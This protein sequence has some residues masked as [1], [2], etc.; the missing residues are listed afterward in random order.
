MQSKKPRHGQGLIMILNDINNYGK[1][2][3]EV[4]EVII[5]IMKHKQSWLCQSKICLHSHKKTVAMHTGLSYT[6]YPKDKCHGHTV[7]ADVSA[8]WSGDRRRVCFL[9]VQQHNTVLFMWHSADGLKW[10]E[11]SGNSWC[12]SWSFRRTFAWSILEWRF[13]IWA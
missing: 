13:L 9:I 11:S 7:I 6:W 10:K 2:M 5:H 1:D 4:W 8:A 3:L 12:H